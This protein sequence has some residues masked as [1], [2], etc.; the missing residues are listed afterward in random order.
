MIISSY[1]QWA[2]GLADETCKAFSNERGKEVSAHSGY[3]SVHGR[4]NRNS[5]RNIHFHNGASVSVRPFRY[6][7]GSAVLY[8]YG[9]KTKR[10]GHPMI[11]F[12]NQHKI[13]CTY[14]ALAIT[15]SLS[16]QIWM[17]ANGK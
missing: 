5:T 13:T 9:R 11:R 7:D 8:T 3:D 6:Y 17:W 12:A 10:L 14:L 4:G 16:I 1:P 15:I 2:G